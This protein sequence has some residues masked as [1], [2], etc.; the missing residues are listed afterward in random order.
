MRCG[1]PAFAFFSWIG[2]QSDLQVGRADGGVGRRGFKWCPSP[3]PHER[4]FFLTV[5]GPNH[6]VSFY[7]KTMWSNS[8]WVGV[9]SGA[10][11]ASTLLA[12]H[13]VIKWGCEM[14]SIPI[15]LRFFFCLFVL[16]C[17]HCSLPVCVYRAHVWEQLVGYIA[18]AAAGRRGQDRRGNWGN[19]RALKCHAGAPRDHRG[20]VSEGCGFGLGFSFFVLFSCF[21]SL[22]YR[23]L[24][25]WLSANTIVHLKWG[26]RV[27]IVAVWMLA[28]CIPLLL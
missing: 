1:V 22:C 2:C 18:R 3:A 10:L 13:K 21:Q 26:N 17:P 6:A 27:V 9:C 11:I 25:W 14:H 8:P 4:L 16:V 19:E 15:Q 12:C 7:S 20:T 23:G 5:V 24:V 28:K